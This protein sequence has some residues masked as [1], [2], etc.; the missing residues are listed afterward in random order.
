ML[1]RIAHILAGVV[2]GYTMFKDV[3]A[4]VALL[5]VFAIYQLVE[6]LIKRDEADVDIAEYGTGLYI[7]TLL[8]MATG[9]V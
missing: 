9:L 4:G 6:Y 7:Y 2:T 3:V 5:A 1:K 8:H